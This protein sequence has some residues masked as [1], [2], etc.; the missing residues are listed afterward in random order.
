MDGER[1]TETETAGQTERETADIPACYE[2]P[3][4][5]ETAATL[6]LSPLL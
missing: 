4:A 3:K 1:Q 5:K 2:T 6:L